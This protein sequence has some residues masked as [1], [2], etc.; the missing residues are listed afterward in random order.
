[1]LAV[2]QNYAL[3]AVPAE[4]DA[5]QSMLDVDPGRQVSC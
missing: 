3:S 4:R 1:V 2:K 5:L